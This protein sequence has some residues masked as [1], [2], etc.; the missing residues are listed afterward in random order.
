LIRAALIFE[1]VVEHR[2]AVLN[3]LPFPDQAGA[4]DG[5]ILRSSAASNG[6]IA[7]VEFFAQ[8]A[9]E[10][11]HLNQ[12]DL[13]RRWKISPRTLERWRWLKQGPEYLKIGGHVVY[14]LEDIER[15]EA[16]QIRNAAAI[17]ISPANLT[18]G[19]R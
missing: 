3:A 16:N 11:R 13:S 14:S 15:Y 5:P 1:A 4:G 2:H 12:I 7:T 8:L 17:T 6:R 19:A 10:V 9:E 18:E